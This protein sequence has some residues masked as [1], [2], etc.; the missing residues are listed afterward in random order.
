M[1]GVPAN[2]CEEIQ[3]QLSTYPV[4]VLE[5]TYQ[6]FSGDI[7]KDSLARMEYVD[8]HRKIFYHYQIILEG[9][10]QTLPFKAPSKCSSSF[11]ELNNLLQFLC[12]G[13]TYWKNIT[14][15]ELAT[16]E[17]ELKEKIASGEII[18][19]T[20][21]HCSDHGKKWN[22]GW[23]KQVKTKYTSAVTVD[24]DNAEPSDNKLSA[25]TALTGPP[26]STA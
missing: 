22:K 14:A 2:I 16:L 4:K 26:E 19:P 9:W 7:I 5:K 21:C 11:Y 13:N 6:M 8:H 23:S 3:Q 15:E 17:K 25:P 18:S 10:P 12:N 20:Q 1:K 24:S